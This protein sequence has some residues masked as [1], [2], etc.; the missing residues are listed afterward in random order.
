MTSLIVAGLWELPGYLHIN[1]WLLLRG[2]VLTSLQ[3]VLRPPHCSPTLSAR[4]VTMS[5]KEKGIW[6]TLKLYFKGYPFKRILQSKVTQIQKKKNMKIHVCLSVSIVAL[7]DRKSPR[8]HDLKHSKFR[9][10]FPQLLH[11]PVKYKGPSGA[12]TAGVGNGSAVSKCCLLSSCQ[13]L[14]PLLGLKKQ[15]SQSSKRSRYLILKLS[16]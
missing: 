5:H 14:P 1:P 15:M 3:N 16:K 11:H 7:L 8:S 13:N 9:A 4:R 6:A 12:T 2:K 10:I